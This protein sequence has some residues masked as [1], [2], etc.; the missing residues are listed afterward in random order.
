MGCQG[1]LPCPPCVSQ[2][3]TYFHKPSPILS[4]SKAAVTT[5]DTQFPGPLPGP[6]CT[7]H[8]QYEVPLFSLLL[9]QTAEPLGLSPRVTLS[10][11][12]STS[13][14]VGSFTTALRHGEAVPPCTPSDRACLRR[15][16][17]ASSPFPWLRWYLERGS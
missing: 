6:V 3:S 11:R 10:P 16:C 12:S 13:P 5:G 8:S 2:A 4:Q 17:E 15:R 14:S 1:S 7:H 9:A